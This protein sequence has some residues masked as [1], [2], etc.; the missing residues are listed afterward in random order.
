M[1]ALAADLSGTLRIGAMLFALSDLL[2][3]LNVALEATPITR[4]VSLAVY[5]I[6]LG[7]IA[8][9]PWRRR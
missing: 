9:S 5:Y 1:V 6:A 3:A 2:L 4:F 8:V 7:L